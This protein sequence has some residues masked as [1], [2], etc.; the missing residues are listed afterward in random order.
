MKEKKP[1]LFV[2]FIFALSITTILYIIARTPSATGY[3]I[4]IY[5]IYPWY[6]WALIIGN[7]MMGSIIIIFSRSR[8]KV[9]YG[10][11][12]VV[13]TNLILLGLQFFRRYFFY[14]GGDPFT[15]I[16]YVRDILL[17]GYISPENFYPFQHILIANINA[18]T[19]I[20]I[21]MSIRLLTILFYI[22]FVLS[23]YILLRKYSLP[24]FKYGLVLGTLLI[25]GPQYTSPL[26]NI[27]SFFYFPLILFLLV[28]LE[29]IPA[30]IRINFALFLV[31]LAIIFFHPITSLY[32]LGILIFF[33]MTN[34]FSRKVWYKGRSLPYLNITILLT[35]GT[36]AFWHLGFTS[37]RMGIRRAIY[38][39]FAEPGLN[40]KA[41]ELIQAVGMFDVQFIDMVRKFI[42][43]FGIVSIL[44][45]MVLIYFIYMNIDRLKFKRFIKQREVLF[46]FLSVLLFAAWA[47][48]NFFADFV[49]FTRVFKFVIL[50][51]FL[52]MGFIF[53]FNISLKVNF[54]AIKHKNTHSFVMV[55]LVTFILITSVFSLYPSSPSFS[56]NRQV[57][58]QENEGMRWLFDVQNE[59]NLIWEEGIRQ[60]RWG[61]FLYGR[62]G[63]TRPGNLRREPNI[64]DHFGYDEYERMGE[65][66]SG[67]LIKTE[68]AI[69]MYRTN[70]PEYEQFWRFNE[71]SYEEFDRDDSVNKI[72]DNGFF[73][74]YYIE[75][76]DEQ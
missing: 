12:F 69:M 34:Y 7:L 41:E 21:E 25:F 50:F 20:P 56:S 29:S 40:P 6:F 15:H 3:E 71:S 53:S 45:L 38:S 33:N 43:D 16:G 62:R 17:T 1:K 58:E 48:I 61:D 37:I 23:L 27:L 14:G 18:T 19:N 47:T 59:G 68:V 74:S 13:I 70:F 8:K 31:A 64:P 10:F 28:K 22:L 9:T 44:F 5:S 65:N 63:E 4:D 55:L 52:L 32:L 73:S 30:K 57:S 60:H 2:T 39:I 67:Y 46:L 42:F 76:V 11:Y 49:T 24:K 26:P 72:Y 51:S 54:A 35:T 36:W 75:E 66:Y